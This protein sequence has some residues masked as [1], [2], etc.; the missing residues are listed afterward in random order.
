[1]TREKF[2]LSL[3]IGQFKFDSNEDLI[4]DESSNAPGV[5]TR[6]REFLRIYQKT[7]HRAVIII[8]NDW[9]VGGV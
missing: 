3:G 9:E 1:M 4:V 8:D 5:F 7:H 2:H 6:A